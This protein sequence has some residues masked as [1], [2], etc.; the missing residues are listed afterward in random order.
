MR[1]S[2]RPLGR[3]AVTTRIVRTADGRGTGERS[4]SKDVSSHNGNHRHEPF[5]PAA[6][7]AAAQ[8]LARAVV[9]AF[10]ACEEA[11]MPLSD[12]QK[13]AVLE[14][15]LLEFDGFEA[16]FQRLEGISELL[17]ARHWSPDEN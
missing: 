13:I 3:A 11:C 10:S 4:P 14:A 8:C 1:Q 2:P 17:R 5:A 12:L 7:V 15:A 9:V 6:Q 16:Q